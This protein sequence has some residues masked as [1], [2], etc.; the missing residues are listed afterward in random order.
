LGSGKASSVSIVLSSSAVV[1]VSVVGLIS[2]VSLIVWVRWSSSI[3]RRNVKGSV[4]SLAPSIILFSEFLPMKPFEMASMSCFF[5]GFECSPWVLW[6][7]SLTGDYGL[8]E[9]WFKAFLEQV[10]GSMIIERNS[11]CCGKS[12][13]LRYEDVKALL[14][15]EISEFIECLILPVGVGKG[16]FEILFKSGPMIF[17]CFVHSSSKMCLEFDHLF[18]LPRFHHVSLHKGK[19]SGDVCGWVAHS[20]IL[21]IGEVVDGECNEEGM[22]LLPVSI[23][24]YGRGS[25]KSSIGGCSNCDGLSTLTD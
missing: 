22:A 7:V 11:S 8:D 4:E 9:C 20:F 23:E 17:V 19:T 1:L 13:E 6:I 24:W 3:L 10:D 25:F 21:P 15:F 14:L 5:P 16:I 18:F 12:F 2:V